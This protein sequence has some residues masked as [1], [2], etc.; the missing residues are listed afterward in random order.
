MISTRLTGAGFLLMV[1]AATPVLRAQQAAA[2]HQ[3]FTDRST[4]EISLTAKDS[5]EIVGITNFSYEVSGTHVP[6]RPSEERLVIRKK[7]RT[8]QV[9][10]EIGMEAV[11]ILEAWPLGTNLEEKPLY[12]MNVEGADAQM[13]NG[14][15][16]EV[17]RG[18][19][20]VEW[21]SIYKLGIGE[22][23]FDTYVPLVQFSI[24]RETVKQRYVGLEVPPDD[25]A[26]ARLKDPHVVGV[27][28][29]ASAE[30]VI[31]E[32]LL[33]CDDPKQAQMLR[34]FADETRAISVSESPRSITI[35]FSR[36]FPSTPATQ[37]VIIPVSKDDLDLARAKFPARMHLAA[38]KR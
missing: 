12:S 24:S 32:A 31:R 34:S 21:W 7:V 25:T 6:G 23:I 16:L 10:D 33:T 11:T 13:V 26:D 1:I 38:W 8:R 17:S 18:V 4:S 35:S 36:N 29:Y 15:L 22:H 19:E 37:T 27:I 14:E 5:E 28:T 30:Q 3:P 20:E 9:L 2:P